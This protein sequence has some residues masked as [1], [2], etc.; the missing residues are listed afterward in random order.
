MVLQNG[1]LLERNSAPDGGGGSVYLSPAAEL[2]YTLPAPPGRWLNIRQGITF[3]LELVVEDLDFPY[4]CSAGV[5]GG[6]SVEDQMGPGCSGP[7]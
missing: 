6:P 3:Q 2:E 1:T 7:W 5:V 4:A